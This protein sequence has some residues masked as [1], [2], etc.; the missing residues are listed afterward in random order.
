MY[1]VKFTLLLAVCLLIEPIG[2]ASAAAED[3][4][5]CLGEIAEADLSA[6]SSHQNSLRDLIVARRPN[7]IALADINRDLQL[8]FA[9]MR[10]ARLQHLISTASGRVDS[11]NGLTQFRNFDWTEEDRRELLGASPA[12]RAKVERLEILKS[13]NNGHPDWPALRAF[14]REELSKEADFKDL[15]ATFQKHNATA[16]TALA[17][18]GS[19]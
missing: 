2:K 18:C 15:I 9:E 7:F 16:E 1:P 19:N 13:K 4:G 8:L 11:T 3:L 5:V 14:V 12:Y 17:D 10:F 6:K